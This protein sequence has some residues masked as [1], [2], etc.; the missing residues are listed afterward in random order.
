[1][2]WKLPHAAVSNTIPPTTVAMSFRMALAFQRAVP[3]KDAAATA[4]VRSD[5]WP[6]TGAT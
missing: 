4:T 5:P 1:M 6:V 2:C 3:T